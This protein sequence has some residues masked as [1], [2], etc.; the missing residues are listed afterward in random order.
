MWQ[1]VKSRNSRNRTSARF[2]LLLTISLLITHS[3]AVAG[4]YDLVIRQARVIDPETGLDGIRDVGIFEGRITAVENQLGQVDADTQVINASGL[5]LAPGFIDMHVHGQSPQAHEYQVR[6]G[7]TT[8]LELEW[9]YPEVGSFLASRQGKARVNYGASVS[10]GALRALAL[11][12]SDTERASLRQQLNQ[13]VTANEPLVAVQPLVAHSF[14]QA[15]SDTQENWLADEIR[16]ELTQGGIGIGMAHSYYPGADRPEIYGVFELAARLNVPLYSHLRG[17]GLD[18]VQEVVANASATGAAIHIVHVN[19]TALGEY[20][21]VLSLIRG[22]QLRGV[23]VTTEAYPYTAGST[24]IQAA[25]FDGN[26]QDSYGISYDGLQWQETGERLNAESFSRYRELGGVVIIHMMQEPW[27]EAAI[28]NDWVMIA[29]DGM[30]YAPGAHPRTSG[31]FSRVLARY[32]RE[33]QL[34]DLPTAIRKMTLMPAQRLEPVAPQMAKKG[35]VQVSADADLVLFDPQTILDTADF[36]T[37]PQF[38]Q[39]IHSVIVNGVL[40]VSEGETVPEAFPGQ[41][42]YGLL[43]TDMTHTP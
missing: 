42:I 30:P 15:L 19:S 11:S 29:S 35:R 24:T 43:P 21:S 16:R 26:W 7:I 37:G 25:M 38:S 2:S 28:A 3:M 36:D 14:Q 23:D 31:T 6:D 9:G 8:A 40:V 10:H 1:R 27:V 33:R 20:Q 5:V 13:A 22:A 17:R 4:E 34:L 12:A 32:V 18:A 39:G 41:A